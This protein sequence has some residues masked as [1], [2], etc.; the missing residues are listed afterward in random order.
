MTRRRIS[1]PAPPSWSG[2][3]RAACNRR[4]HSIRQ[5]KPEPVGDDLVRKILEVVQTAP[6]AGNLQAF[7]VVV[8]R[9]AEKKKGLAAAAYGQ[10]FIA[11]APVVLGF[12]ALPLASARRYGQRGVRLYSIQDA[13][14]ACTYAMLAVTALGLSTTWVGSYDDDEVRAVLKAGADQVPVALLPIGW[15]AEEGCPT[16][17][18][19]MEKIARE[20]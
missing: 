14:I 17:R 13:T 8:V 15:G 18:R 2:S 9:D 12:L 1:P 3:T 20:V 16:S 11:E 4:R 5:F 19:P 10:R 6:T 7:E